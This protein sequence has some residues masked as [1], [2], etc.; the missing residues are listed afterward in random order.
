MGFFT[1]IIADSRYMPKMGEVNVPRPDLSWPVSAQQDADSTTEAAV[2]NHRQQSALVNEGAL[3][4]ADSSGSPVDSVSSQYAEGSLAAKPP[5]LNQPLS[6]E[7]TAVERV[8]RPASTHINTAPASTRVLTGRPPIQLKPA[9]RQGPTVQAHH[10]PMADD[11]V[12]TSP[13]G[14]E[15]ID[16]NEARFPLPPK[17]TGESREGGSPS[18]V[19]KAA[20]QQPEMTDGVARPVV[21]NDLVAE[22]EKKTVEH[23]KVEES[24][25]RPSHAAVDA[26]QV[27]EMSKI[28]LPLWVPELKPADNTAEHHSAS[29]GLPQVRIGQVNVTVERTAQPKARS[30][31]VRDDSSFVS[32]NFLKGL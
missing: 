18:S 7:S 26:Q 24:Q 21:K 19:V 8:N 25:V 4:V 30:A 15:R 16:R 9:Q 29:S 11:N 3:Q 6:V 10:S 32:R 17:F 27:E 20:L 23:L 28:A 5:L 14:S 22:T 31:S 1:D 13:S 2:V 12:S